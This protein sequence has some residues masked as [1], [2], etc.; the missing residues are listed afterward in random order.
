MKA[1]LN[2]VYQVKLFLNGLI[3]VFIIM[4]MTFDLSVIAGGDDDY[5]PVEIESMTFMSKWLSSGKVTLAGGMYR[6]TTV[7]GSASETI[8]KL[9]GKR[10][11][12]II[13]GKEA[14]AVILIT[15]P[16]GSGTFYDVALVV[17]EGQGWVNT[18]TVFLGDRVNIEA[19]GITGKNIDVTMKTHSPSDPM[20]CPSLEV[21]KQFAVKENRLVPFAG[22]P[23][24]MSSM[25]IT[26]TVWHWVQTRYSDDRKTAPVDPENYSI[27]FYE[28]GLL[29]VNADCNKKGG[30]YSLSGNKVSLQIA[31][32]TAAECPEGSLEEPF[33]KD[34]TA[35]SI[36]FIKN[37]DL[38]IELQ[39]DAGTIKLIKGK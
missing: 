29:K 33:E 19:I 21:V 23:P 7:P 13:N 39:S 26:G 5:A 38:Y 17:K 35:G 14:G 18:D 30:T 4:L 16:G 11:F 25:D 22:E 32:S 20:C 15:D 8:V 2:Q 9:S 1:K 31:H 36:F 6:E 10:T 28:D 12:G 24:E 37:G 34:L 27:Q 3:F